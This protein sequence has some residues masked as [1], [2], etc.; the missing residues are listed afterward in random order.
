GLRKCALFPFCERQ[1]TDDTFLADEGEKATRLE[2]VRRQALIE[3][4]SFL[5]AID[6]RIVSHLLKTVRHQS[7]PR[8]EVQAGSRSMERQTGILEEVFAAT[9]IINDRE[10][11]IT[12]VVFVG[13]SETGKITV[14][15]FTQRQRYCMKELPNFQFG[16]D[17]IVDIKQKLQPIAFV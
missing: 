3:N 16:R 2:L 13:K 1:H 4:S 15:H 12:V 7:R 14:H 9:G 17:G 6:F 8:A 5:A 11:K 10:A